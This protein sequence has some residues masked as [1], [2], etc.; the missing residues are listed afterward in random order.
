MNVKEEG[1]IERTR[2]EKNNDI[3]EKYKLPGEGDARYYNRIL[4]ILS[5]RQQN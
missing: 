1:K 3:F 4:S 2:H 5:K